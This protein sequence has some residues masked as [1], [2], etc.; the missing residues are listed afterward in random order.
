MNERESQR[1]AKTGSE[2]GAI[3]RRS[4]EIRSEPR[5][6]K[7][8]NVAAAYLQ[9]SFCFGESLQRTRILSKR[10]MIFAHDT[11]QASAASGI[12]RIRGRNDWAVV[13]VR[14]HHLIVARYPYQFPAQPQSTASQSTHRL[15]Q[16]PRT[17]VIVIARISPSP[18]CAAPFQPD[19]HRFG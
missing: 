2:E 6:R 17:R 8:A 15:S 12:S 10:G 19:F 13:V 11:K 5:G 4:C 18:S 9:N 14:A 1:D 16:I 3:K 7:S